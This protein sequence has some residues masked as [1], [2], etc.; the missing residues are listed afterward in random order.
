MQRLLCRW[1][2]RPLSIPIGIIIYRSLL[3]LSFM[4]PMRDSIWCHMLVRDLYLYCQRI[5]S[6]CRRDTTTCLWEYSSF[7][8]AWEHLF[9]T[10]TCCRNFVA[11][12]WCGNS[13]LC[14]VKESIFE[15]DNEVVHGFYEP[16]DV[17]RRF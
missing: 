9:N 14:I 10:T 15:E 16:K 3:V 6:L 5:S 4:D 2:N 7:L 8:C 13:S 17:A 1:R 12:C 11:T